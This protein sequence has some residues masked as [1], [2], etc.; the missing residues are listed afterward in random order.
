MVKEEESSHVVVS[1][2]NNY[3]VNR[4]GQRRLNSLVF[5]AHQRWTQVKRH[6]SE[7]RHGFEKG[8]NGKRQTKE[9]VSTTEHNL[10]LAEDHDGVDAVGALAEVPVE[11]RGHHSQTRPAVHARKDVFL[12]FH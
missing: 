9:T 11:E 3:F 10:V 1:R 8:R 5:T 12:A 2:K 4:N 7:K 6:I